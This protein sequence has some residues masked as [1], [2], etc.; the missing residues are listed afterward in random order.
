MTPSRT[1]RITLKLFANRPRPGGPLKLDLPE[2]TKVSDVVTGYAT[3]REPLIV[4]VN[5]VP[6]HSRDRLLEDGDLVALFPQ[7]EGG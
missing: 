4:V 6:E 5:G 3:V 2:G 7:M 1:I